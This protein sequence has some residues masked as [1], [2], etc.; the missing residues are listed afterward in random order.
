MEMIGVEQKK[1]LVMVVFHSS[2]V[3]YNSGTAFYTCSSLRK[4]WFQ[5]SWSK[6]VGE[7]EATE[8][9]SK[10]RRPRGYSTRFRDRGM[11]LGGESASGW[12]D[13]PEVSVAKVKGP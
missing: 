3:L 1:V 4:V 6:S 2:S 11:I 10:E 7:G 8:Y 9:L 5:N 13:S 12:E